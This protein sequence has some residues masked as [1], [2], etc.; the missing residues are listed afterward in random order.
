MP[1]ISQL[2]L[3]LKN[4]GFPSEIVDVYKASEIILKRVG[5]ER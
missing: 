3:K 4:H 1:E 5:E 2:F